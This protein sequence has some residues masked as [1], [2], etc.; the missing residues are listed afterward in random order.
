MP[1]GT[2]GTWS[3]H[4]PQPAPGDALAGRAAVLDGNCRGLH[5]PGPLGPHPAQN[6]HPLFT[7]GVPRA[8]RSELL[9][10]EVDEAIASP[11]LSWG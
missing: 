4:L 7:G 1:R 6:A 11:D 8:F 9:R 3:P 10:R 2:A 5:P